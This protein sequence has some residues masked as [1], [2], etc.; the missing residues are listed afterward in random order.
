MS[1]PVAPT[2][3]CPL[4]GGIMRLKTTETVVRV[5]HNPRTV[6]RSTSEWVCPDCDYFEE[7]DEER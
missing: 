2:R 5:P 3:E 1:P 6:T 7:V 4:C